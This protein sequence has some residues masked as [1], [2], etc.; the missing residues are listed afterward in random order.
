MLNQLIILLVKKKTRA[1]NGRNKD[2]FKR[3]DYSILNFNTCIH[4]YIYKYI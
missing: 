4:V 1:E 2:K 3:Q